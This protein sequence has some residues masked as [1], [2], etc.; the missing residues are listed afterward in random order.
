[1]CSDRVSFQDLLGSSWEGWRVEEGGKEKLE[2]DS[3][4]GKE[5]EEVMPLR[6]SI[7]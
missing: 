2:G 5:G 3:E 7:G 4:D 1:M 6:G